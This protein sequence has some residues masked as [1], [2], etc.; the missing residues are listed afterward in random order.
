M[1]KLAFVYIRHVSGELE[2]KLFFGAR[3]VAEDAMLSDALDILNEQATANPYSFDEDEHVGIMTDAYSKR[4][5]KVNPDFD[6][7]RE[8]VTFWL[9]DFNVKV[10]HIE[11]RL[12]SA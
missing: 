9:R 11:L 4:G 8:V 5:F 6:E 7:T 1:N 12:G 10:T 3:D 2:A